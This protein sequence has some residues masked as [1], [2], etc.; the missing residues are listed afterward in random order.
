MNLA[1]E[2]SKLSPGLDHTYLTDHKKVSYGVPQ[3]S[4]FGPILVSINILLLGTLIVNKLG[5]KSYADDTQLYTSLL[6]L[7]PAK[8]EEY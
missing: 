6:S 2:N 7:T 4:V 5:S 8:R 1:S 3:G